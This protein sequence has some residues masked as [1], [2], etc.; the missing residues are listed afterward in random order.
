LSLAAIVAA[1][2]GALALIQAVMPWEQVSIGKGLSDAMSGLGLAAD[3]ANGLEEN[4]G[5]I[6]AV[7]GIAA[8]ALAVAWV[9]R[10]K[11]PAIPVLV[12]VVGVLI[13]LVGAA[14]YLARG[15]DISDFNKSLDTLKAYGM[16]TSGT[17]YSVGLGMYLGILSGIVVAAGGVLG[18]TRKS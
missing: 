13:V 6:I 7:L 9:L 4:G 14:N 11:I 15:N 18:L 8:I 5:K 17:S 16:D 12:L 10:A 3:T 1:I 2:G